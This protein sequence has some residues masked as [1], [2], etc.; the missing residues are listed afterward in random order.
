MTTTTTT[1]SYA[2]NLALE[3]PQRFN[4]GL[5]REPGRVCDECA[6]EFS[7]TSTRFRCA[8]C[9]DHYECAACRTASCHTHQIDIAGNR[10]SNWIQVRQPITPASS[11]FSSVPDASFAARIKWAFTCFAARPC[12]GQQVN[13]EPIWWTF[14]DVNRRVDAC[15]TSLVARVHSHIERK[16]YCHCTIEPRPCVAI[17]GKNSV[18]WLVADLAC[19]LQHYVVVPLDKDMAWADVLLIL[20]DMHVAILFVDVALYTIALACADTVSIV[21]MEGG[22]N[23]HNT[24]N[25][26]TMQ[27]FENDALSSLLPPPPIEYARPECIVTVTYTSGTTGITPKGVLISDRGHAFKTHQASPIEEA[28]LRL[29]SFLAFSN[30]TGRG[31]AMRCLCIGGS[32]GIVHSAGTLVQDLADWIHPTVFVA[33]PLVWSTLYAG[34]C[35]DVAHLVAASATASPTLVGR[36]HKKHLQEVAAS[37]LRVRLGGCVASVAVGG[38]KAAPELVSFLKQCFGAENA[39]D[40]YGATECGTIARDGVVLPGVTI[41]LLD[42]P[43]FSTTDRPWP[44]GELCVRTPNMAVGYTASSLTDTTFIHFPEEEKLD[45][46][47]RPFYRT[48]DVCEWR[49]GGGALWGQSDEITILARA[50]HVIKLSNGMFVS[51]EAVE[52][53]L[54]TQLADCLLHAFLHA[55]VGADAL[56]AILVPHSDITNE[57]T[58]DEWSIRLRQCISLPPS[59]QPRHFWVDRTSRSSWFDRGLL[60]STH[61]KRRAAIADAYRSQLNSLAVVVPDTTTTT[62]KSFTQLASEYLHLS[63]VTMLHT[64]SWLQL[65]GNSMNAIAFAHQAG[66]GGIVFNATDLLGRA[67]VSSL[68]STKEGKEEIV[69]WDAECHLPDDIR[70]LQQL[71]PPLSTSETLV[72]LSGAAGF[73]GSFLLAELLKLRTRGVR[74]VCIIRATST[75]EARA[76]VARALY[77]YGLRSSEAYAHDFLSRNVQIE[78]GDMA[79][80]EFGLESDRYDDLA[81]RVTHVI[82]NASRV[83]FV[84]PYASLRPDNVQSTL[85]VLR[86]CCLNRN[87][88]LCYVSTRSTRDCTRTNVSRFSGYTQS[89][90]VA[91][92]LVL[93]ARNTR[94]FT[95]AFITRPSSIIGDSRTGYGPLHV[96]TDMLS[97]LWVGCAQIGRLHIVECTQQDI[98]TLA[99]LDQW[100]DNSANDEVLQLVGIPQ[101][102]SLVPVDHVARTTVGLLLAT[103]TTV[104]IV[105]RPRDAIV[106]LANP[107]ADTSMLDLLLA[108]DLD[109][110]TP[111]IVGQA[112]HQAWRSLLLKD[113]NS[114]LPQCLVPFRQLLLLQQRQ[115]GSAQPKDADGN[116]PDF[117]NILY[118]NRACP[119]VDDALLLRC[120]RA[121]FLRLKP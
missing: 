24:T 106:T 55:P 58:D 54:E 30:S 121:L 111:V 8:Y 27:A 61:K 90:Y 28:G 102:F 76:R 115:D 11:S 37:W 15:R 42:T 83:N 49:R 80:S 56:V 75:D 38:A 50:S 13:N 14:A 25:V 103:S 32:L 2:S 35:D 104:V 5:L 120:F 109:P 97:A 74:V 70:A 84:Y 117:L 10:G 33:P 113:D 19:Q 73:L 116:D 64:H 101:S 105:R 78:C 51:P 107:R 41:R 65:G 31:Q 18:D 43:G 69:D 1:T 89:K 46:D 67:P 63:D 7:A 68:L 52:Q 44:R 21:V 81:A 112:A 23:V 110:T 95:D 39:V 12:V 34:Y 59:S 9:R 119:I 79:Q 108:I 62:T 29:A 87:K 85:E 118:Y 98:T 71:P 22:D 6:C 94:G 17:W 92:Q 100:M 114:H 26:S 82:H 40:T 57:L 77:S 99:D 93:E 96:D 20:R 16:R 45:G 72:L 4:L 91:E 3:R 36:A 48:G 47:T 86:F 88:T 53:A 66:N 60:T